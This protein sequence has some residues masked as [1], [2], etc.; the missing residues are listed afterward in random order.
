MEE[1]KQIVG[2]LGEIRQVPQ[3]VYMESIGLKGSYTV[4]K[5]I[6]KFKHEN[7]QAKE[8]DLILNSGGGSAHDAYRIIKLFRNNF[9]TVNVVVPYWAKSAA[10]LLALGAHRVIL[11][12]MGEL[13]PLDVQIHKM[14]EDSPDFA[15]ESALT[16]EHSL[17]IIE[18]RSRSL[19]H[20]MF[21][22]TYANA[23]IPINRNELAE[24]LFDYIAKFYQPLLTQISPFKLGDNKRKLDIAE[25]YARRI[26]GMFNHNIPEEKKNYLIDYLVNGCP[27]HEYVVDYE[28]I[29]RLLPTVMRAAELGP[30][31]E[32]TLAA[33]C[34]KM[35]RTGSEITL[36]GFLSMGE[37]LKSTARVAER[38]KKTNAKIKAKTPESKEKKPE[39]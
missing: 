30:D 5:E 16:D 21:E 3:F 10:T 13:G 29:K 15:K 38:P 25:H 37:P 19:F 22:G 14:R 33:M 6:L 36:I 17:K 34:D 2:R 8:I 27:D 12:D 39:E 9:N 20:S 18:T 11:D 24:L 28:L 4:R 7:R 32:M 26:L 1:I 35:I 31:Y 23:K